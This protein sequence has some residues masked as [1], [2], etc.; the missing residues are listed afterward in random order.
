MIRALPHAAASGLLFFSCVAAYA[1]NANF[2]SSH[3]SGSGNCALCHDGLT[4]VTGED[5]S[6]VRDWGPSMMANSTKDPFWKAKLASELERNSHLTELLS[7]VCTKCHAPMANY[8]ITQVQG[9][10]ITLFG[11]DGILDPAHPLYDAAQNGVSCTVCHQIMDDASLGTLEGFSGGYTIN[12]QKHIYG[13][14]SDILARPMINN[15]GYTPMFSA[16]I[17]DSALCAVCHNLKTPFVDADGNVASTTLD[18]EFPEQMPYTEWE[19][20]EFEDAGTNPQSCQDCHMPR[21]TSKLSNRPSFVGTKDGF[22]KHYFV[23]ANT[24]MLTLLRDNAAQL[25][26]TSPDMDLAIDRA[27]EMLQGAATIEIVSAS[28]SDGVLEARLK[29]QNEAGHKTP[30]SYPSRRMWI[31]FKVT[32]NSNN[33]V[34]ES[35]RINADGSIT[36]ANSDADPA[37]YEPHYD[38][39]TSADQVQIYEP[40]VA[41]T[42]GN[43]TYTL[44]RSAYYLKDNRLT[45][46]G[47]DKAGVPDDVAVRGLAFNDADFNLGSDEIIYRVPVSVAGDLTVSA[48][49]NYQTISYAFLQDLYSESQ[50]EQVQTFKNLYDPQSLK[51]EQMA[52]V[53]TVVASDVD[54][55]DTDNDGVYDAAD[56][57]I[58]VAN[59]AQRDTD[60]DNFG[61]YCDPDFDNNLVINASDLAYLKSVYF[62]D[63]PNADLDGNGNVNGADLSILKSMYLEA[64]GPSGLVP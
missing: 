22:A 28:V 20:S 55:T 29:I 8:E 51:H 36:G 1:E 63:H 31:H 7:D 27:R 49:L 40:V 13:Q 32:D 10:A 34:F 39:I 58:L 53:Q 64:P 37:T 44:L 59:P 62:I 61:N 33:V 30:T 12:D 2:T 54:R 42:D 19:H 4:D 14:Y 18:S 48:A 57:C 26:V 46:R 9:D 60:N 47:F 52:N 6:I 35:G 43:V 17:S 15:T 21:T 56:N 38:Q 50:L 24:T 3:F 16:H 41:D 11:D 23:G 25:D 5:V 45:P